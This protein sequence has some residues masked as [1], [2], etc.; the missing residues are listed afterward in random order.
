MSLRAVALTIFFNFP[1]YF[2]CRFLV[3]HNHTDRITKKLL[4][5]SPHQWSH[6]K[7]LRNLYFLF[8]HS[9][10]WLNKKLSELNCEKNQFSK[11]HE[12]MT[13]L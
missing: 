10:N 11:R 5:S 13:Y 8:A 3:Q 9:S 6:E 7:L 1:F 2:L 4:H 12:R